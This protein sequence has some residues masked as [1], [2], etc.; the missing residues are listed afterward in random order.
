MRGHEYDSNEGAFIF[1][2]MAI[3]AEAANAQEIQEDMYKA[4]YW[5]AS[6]KRGGPQ[7]KLR[8]RSWVRIWRSLMG[9]NP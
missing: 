9:H 6:R 3:L 8:E 1:M 5:E 4:K 2:V 7:L